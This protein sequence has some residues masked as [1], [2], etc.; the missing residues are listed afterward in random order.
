MTV[1]LADLTAERPMGTARSQRTAGGNTAVVP[2]LAQL[3]LAFALSC[4]G[5]E[6]SAAP[7]GSSAVETAAGE[8]A[9]A[10]LRDLG[11]RIFDSNIDTHTDIR[12]CAI[13]ALNT[14]Q[15]YIA[16]D[17]GPSWKGTDADLASIGE[18]VSLGDVELGVGLQW[19]SPQALAGLKLPGSLAVLRLDPAD[20]RFEQLQGLP[21]CRVLGLGSG[22]LTPARCR[23]VLELA[24]DI[25]S[26]MLFDDRENR[27]DVA[28]DEDSEA[29]P[30]GACDDTLA[31]L[32]KLP[33]LKRLTISCCPI[34]DAGLK[35]LAQM[36]SLES[37]EIEQCPGLE[38]SDFAG[39]VGVGTL[40][41]LELDSP[42]SAAGLA[43]ISRLDSLEKLTLIVEDLRPEDIEPLSRLARLKEL[44]LQSVQKDDHEAYLSQ[45]TP[46]SRLAE[47]DVGNAI[48]RA[49]GNLPTLQTL[50]IDWA[51]D[52]E[53][54]KSLVALKE[55]QSVTLELA[56]VDDRALELV[57]S[58]PRLKRLGL[59]GKPKLSDQGLA[60]LENATTLVELRVPGKGITD[61]G[62]AHLAGLTALEELA[63]RANI[64][65]AGFGAP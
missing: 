2:A 29:P 8:K 1:T 7:P 43:N 52:H 63:L 35:H 5:F 17:L 38:K 45:L 57:G 19:V 13:E 65:D 46:E 15:R 26:L 11:A 41:S 23:H 30:P 21:A 51:I 34:T 49:A 33:Q 6:L 24:A 4:A 64:T 44:S 42:L 50:L 25:E 60:H 20:Q 16:I 14:A 40:R 32:S 12:I 55:L 10:Q 3:V 39:L 58:L 62:L 47:V 59:L 22:S 27:A 56:E 61:A 36:K 37:L 9:L 31:E 28:S 48:A 53:G 18:V 54:L